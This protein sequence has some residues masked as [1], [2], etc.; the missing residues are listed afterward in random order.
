ME[1]GIGKGFMLQEIEMSLHR[2][3]S[4]GNVLDEHLR[5]K[6]TSA[7]IFLCLECLYAQI[8]GK[9]NVRQGSSVEL[10]YNDREGSRDGTTSQGCMAIS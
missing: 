5:D 6:H 9:I 10:K 2:L 8:N 4:T 3:F 1:R 7:Q